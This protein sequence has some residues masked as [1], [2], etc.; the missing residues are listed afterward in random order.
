MNCDNGAVILLN[1]FFSKSNTGNKGNIVVFF[2]HQDSIQINL[3]HSILIIKLI[4]GVL[5]ASIRS[6]W[7]ISHPMIVHSSLFG[8]NKSIR[9][10]DHSAFADYRSPSPKALSK[11]KLLDKLRYHYTASRNRHPPAEADIHILKL[12]FFRSSLLRHP[13]ERLLSTRW[14]HKPCFKTNVKKSSA[15]HHPLRATIIHCRSRYPPSLKRNEPTVQLWSG[16]DNAQGKLP[17]KVSAWPVCWQFHKFPSQL[18]FYKVRNPRAPKTPNSECSSNHSL[19]PTKLS[20]N[21]RILSV[22]NPR[23]PIPWK[24]PPESRPCSRDSFPATNAIPVSRNSP[25]KKSPETDFNIDFR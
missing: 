6:P 3:S 5:P 16:S 17:L 22:H 7:K 25:Q 2:N 19:C 4:Q 8:L 15:I 18:S 12:N 24:K 9:L 10:S 20:P 21:F 14:K 23:F 13:F 1:L 11:N